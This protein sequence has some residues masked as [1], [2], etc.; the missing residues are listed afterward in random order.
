MRDE[1]M[2]VCGASCPYGEVLLSSHCAQLCHGMEV[3]RCRN[4]ASAQQKRVKDSLEESHPPAHAT[5][6]RP[7][8]EMVGTTGCHDYRTTHF[9]R[10]VHW[11]L[12]TLLNTSHIWAAG[13]SPVPVTP[14]GC[15]PQLGKHAHFHERLC[16]MSFHFKCLAFH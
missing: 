5:C 15:T 12:H 8:C 6:E 13:M 1:R 9:T 4:Q 10:W 14:V 16:W 3:V 2:C 11:A 7:A